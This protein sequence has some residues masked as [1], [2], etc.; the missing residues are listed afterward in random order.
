MNDEGTV[1]SE[2]PAGEKG[3]SAAEA[4]H[5]A[6][7]GNAVDKESPADA[8]RAKAIKKAEEKRQDAIKREANLRRAEAIEQKCREMFEMRYVSVDNFVKCWLYADETGFYNLK[9]DETRFYDVKQALDLLSCEQAARRLEIE[10]A[11]N[12][13]ELAYWKAP[14]APTVPDLL[15]SREAAQWVIK[16]RH[17]NNEPLDLV[18]SAFEEILNKDKQTNCPSIENDPQS[19]PKVSKKLEIVKSAYDKAANSLVA[20]AEKADL[21]ASE[22]PRDIAM[23]IIDE[24]VV[25]G[26]IEKSRLPSTTKKK[27]WLKPFKFGSP[28]N[29]RRKRAQFQLFRD[30]IGVSNGNKSQSNIP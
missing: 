17:A 26:G 20:L 16:R 21:K 15:D 30:K 19:E 10:G 4:E 24:L 13:G 6:E 25:K 2:T 22:I 3:I 9:A 18:E 5:G 29:G 12:R 7:V 28:A 27:D 8:V 14:A 1:I 11:I 23:K